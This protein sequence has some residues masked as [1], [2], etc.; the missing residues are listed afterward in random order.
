MKH[1]K[2]AA[3]ICAIVACASLMLA[4]CSSQEYKPAPKD[5]T[6]PASALGS[7]GTLRVGVDASHPPLAGKPVNNPN[8]EIIGIDVDV[9]AYLADQMGLKVQIVDVGNDPEAALKEGKVDIVLGVDVSETNGTYWRSEPYLETAIALFGTA[10]ETSV[11]TIDSKPKIAAQASTTS[12]WRVTNLFGDAS[13]VTQ[14][15][16]KAAFESMNSGA[17]RYVA[18]DAVVGTYVAQVNGYNDKIVALLEDPTGFCVAVASDN[19]DLQS[20]VATAVGKLVNGGVMNIIEQKWLGTTLNLDS[21]T[22][23]KSQLADTS[24]ASGSSASASS[25][26]ASDESA[27]AESASTEGESTEEGT[28]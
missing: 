27:S 1:W 15:N 8:G 6:V 14:D 28:N 16:L 10:T 18:S 12:S 24:S 5:Q 2:I 25:A 13:L 21:M 23:V 17:S 4:G 19:T 20:A 3:L 11:P 7:N 22:V 9:A 26:S